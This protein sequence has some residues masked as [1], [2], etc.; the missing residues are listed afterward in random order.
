MNEIKLGS[1]VRDMVTGVTGIAVARCEYLNGCVQ[2]CL[3]PPA[4]KGATERP[5]GVY[6][7]VGQLEVVGNGI[8]IPQRPTGGPQVDAPRA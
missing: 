2:Y 5:E 3:V 8:N 4:K 1:K 7:D 6:L